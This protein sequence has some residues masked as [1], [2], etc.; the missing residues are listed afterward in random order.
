MLPG[1]RILN[2]DERRCTGHVTGSSTDLVQ[3]R[4]LATRVIWEADGLGSFACDDP[5]HVGNAVRFMPIGKFFTQL[6]ESIIAQDAER[7]L[8]ACIE[9]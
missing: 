5:G 7:A 9:P 4:A 6:H 8:A 3:C 2:D 1:G